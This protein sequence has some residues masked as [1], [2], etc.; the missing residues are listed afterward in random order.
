MHES[1]QLKQKKLVNEK[2]PHVLKKIILQC[3]NMVKNLLKPKSINVKTLLS[4]NFSTFRLCDHLINRV[5]HFLVFEDVLMAFPAKC[6]QTFHLDMQ[7][8]D[9]F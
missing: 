1:M 8:L 9:M 6:T 3:L 7:N 5:I 2:F 4:L